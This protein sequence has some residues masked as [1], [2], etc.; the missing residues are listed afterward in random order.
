MAYDPATRTMLLFGGQSGTYPYLGDTWGWNG[1][2][3][4]QLSPSTNPSARNYAPMAYDAAT[5]TVL[6]SGGWARI[7]GNEYGGAYGPLSDT[8]G[9]NGTTWTKLSPRGNPGSSDLDS[10]AYDPAT[11]TVLLF[12]GCC[13]P[14]FG[15]PGH[16]QTWS[17]NGTTWTRLSP[18]NSPPLSDGLS[19]AYDP[20]TATVLLLLGYGY[21]SDQTWSWNGITWTR[22]SPPTSPPV[23]RGWSMAYDPATATV[24]L[25]GGGRSN[26]TSTGA[27]S[28]RLD[29]GETW[30]WNGTTWTKLSPGSSPSARDGASMAYDPGTKAMLLFG[31]GYNEEFNE[32]WTLRAPSPPRGH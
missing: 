17:W 27:M 32:T 14:S 12:N 11:R 19:M 31:G 2:T 3:W 18:P 15:P 8:W 29:L 1:T 13:T 30:S 4:T 7:S 6:L 23:S 20:A 9:W 25:F 10:M 22:L 26:R 21:S 28:P 16:G 24:L 5:R